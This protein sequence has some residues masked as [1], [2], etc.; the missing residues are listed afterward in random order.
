M[1]RMSLSELEEFLDK[2][3]RRWADITASPDA[4]RE[5]TVLSR[6]LP[7][8]TH[9]LALRAGQIAVSEE[10]TEVTL[11]DVRKAVLACALAPQDQFGM[12]T[13][14][15][16]RATS[17]GFSFRSEGRFSGAADRNDGR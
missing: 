17:A 5:I 6:R 7:H 14:G 11:A 2:G 3:C 12:F 8:L 13:P 15:S 4:I 16:V 1:P 9:L 10:G